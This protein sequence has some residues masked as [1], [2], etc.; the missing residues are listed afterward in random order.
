M[1]QPQVG[2]ASRL[3]LVAAV[4]GVAFAV[5]PGG[6]VILAL[7]GLLTSWAVRDMN[8]AER[9]WTLTIL[10]VAIGARIAAIGL[11]A[12]SADPEG[13]SFAAL[14]PD[15]HYA[16]ARSLW[17]RNAAVG[18]AVAPINYFHA[19]RP[20]YGSTAYNTVLAAVH[21]WFGPSPYAVHFLSTL[22]FFAAVIVLFRVVRASYGRFA[23]LLGLGVL[24]FMPT[25][26]GW[27]ASPLKE[28]PS[29]VLIAIAM[30]SVVAAVRA[31]DLAVR[32]AA[33]PVAVLALAAVRALRPDGLW[34]ALAGLA[35]GVAAYVI[36]VRRALV[37]PALAVMVVA[38][39][40]ALGVPRVRD[41]IAAQ[42]TAAATRHAAYSLSVGHSYRLLDDRYYPPNASSSGTFSA[43][44]DPR[45]ALRFLARAAVRFVTAPEPWVVR[46]RREVAVIP[47]QMLWYVLLACAAYGVRYGYARAP[48]LTCLMAGLVVAS[49]ALIGPASGN[50][51]TLVRHRD[52][53]MPWLAWLSGAGAVAAVVAAPARI[54]RW[55]AVDAGTAA[56]V[57]FTV[58]L[59]A[60]LFWLFRA[61]AP[62]AIEVAPRELA[63]G[64]RAVLRGAHLEPFLRVFVVATGGSFSMTDRDAWPPEGKYWLRTE[65]EAQVEIPDLPPGV[66]DLALADGADVLTTVP[67]AFTVPPPVPSPSITLTVVGRFVGLEPPVAERLRADAARMVEPW[68]EVVE[69]DQ[70]VL[71]RRVFSI[72]GPWIPAIV[73]GRSQVPATLR[74]RCTPGA[75]DCQAHGT[76]FAAGVTV[77]LPI[78]G[79]RLLFAV[80]HIEGAG[81]TSQT[82]GRSID[83]SA[84]FV[85]LP[86]VARLI[87]AGDRDR[88][89][90]TYPSP[91][92]A[93]VIRIASRFTVK[94]TAAFAGPSN[95]NRF[96]LGTT[97]AEVDAVI[98]VP[99]AVDGTSVYRGQR[100]VPG[101]PLA[102]ETDR[103]IM[104]GYVVTVL[105]GEGK[106]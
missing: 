16:V 105:G 102:F 95:V 50:F 12:L 83:V 100:M 65:D 70:P 24:A 42:I 29:A 27:S 74:V 91:S 76:A 68:M 79:M 39:A 18:V 77:A 81:A 8:G 5:S 30:L 93:E 13:G 104:S 89:N 61:P 7:L 36:S 90:E 62:R 53:V 92:A 49:W 17:I 58:P 71:D 47:Q 21:L 103:Y 37:M 99:A 51:G 84:R 69:L 14:F 43:A 46:G 78:A 63:A 2:L 6:C 3:S 1:P 96:L 26:F 48:L 59:G 11:I 31:P 55:N 4:L 44:A 38:A 56:L 28:A 34:I 80:D 25:L 10:V 54:G 73:E 97:G 64:Q 67:R 88:P 60:A 9:R 15:G 35:L 32:L 86:E 41:R 22:W 40:V 66:Y 87:R 75:T 33:L 106:R 23:A 20:D 82:P 52:S 101:A 57:A 98:R 85:V 19:F 45:G 94:G 72:G